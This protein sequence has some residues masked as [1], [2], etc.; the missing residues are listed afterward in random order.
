MNNS[1]TS[2]TYVGMDVHKDIIAVAILRPGR[3][4]ADEQAVPNR[5]EAVRKLV[6]SWKHPETFRVCY[7]AGPTGYGLQRQLASLGVPCQVVAPA[8]VPR[9]PGVRIK[10]DRRDALSLAGLYRAGELTP[11]RVPSAEEEAIRDLVRLREDLK[12]DVLR[13][14]HRLSK[15][16]LRHGRIYEGRSWTGAHTRWLNAQEF[17][18][19]A[20]QSTFSHYRTA[21]DLRL[22]QLAGLE[23]DLEVYSSGPPF[24]EM[25]SRLVCLRGISHLSALTIACEVVDFARFGSPEEF[26]AFVGLVPSEYSSGRSERRGSIT[27]TGNAHVR[28]VLVEAAWHYRHHPGV[29][30]NLQRRSQG[31]PPEML[32]AAWQVQVRLCE[33]FRRLTTRGKRS[34][35]AVVA[36][37]RELAEAVCALMQRET[38]TA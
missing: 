6:S 25:V 21:L 24:G 29:G 20:E 18:H 15:F 7:E 5:P 22:A 8:L 27:K 35:V 3:E 26:A 14:R 10:T 31:Q 19:P 4:A 36:V 13:A 23:R 28:R 2:L 17:S 30:V 11:I 38:A 16:L 37:A 32:A 9:R 33:R 34:S 1:T 12:Q